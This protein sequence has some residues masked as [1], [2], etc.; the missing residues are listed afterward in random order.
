MGRIMSIIL[1]V[2]SIIGVI[3]TIYGFWQIIPDVYSHIKRLYFPLEINQ[4]TITN[5]YNY[6]IKETILVTNTTD[7]T[8]YDIGI[9]MNVSNQQ[10]AEIKK[11][12]KFDDGLFETIGNQK[13]SK[14][15]IMIELLNAKTDIH[16]YVLRLF[17]I[18]KSEELEVTIP[19]KTTIKLEFK[20][21]AEKSNTVAYPNMN[22]MQVVEFALTNFDKYFSKKEKKEREDFTVTFYFFDGNNIMKLLP[23]GFKGYTGEKTIV[24]P[25]MFL[26]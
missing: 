2:F 23:F 14:E 16:F 24:N 7:K 21:F 6:P 12:G 20:G 1:Y 19:P 9:R 8:I 13:I 15:I 4:K 11:L 26:K 3:A 17:R 18:E 25:I 10:K 22:G 5:N